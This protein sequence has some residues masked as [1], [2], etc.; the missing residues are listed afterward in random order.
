M[1]PV[2][3]GSSLP[4]S[5][6]SSNCVIWQGPDIPCISLCNGDTVSDVV[7]KL[8]TEVCTLIDTVCQ[9][10]PDLTGLDLMCILPAC[11][12]TPVGIKQVLQAIIDYICNYMPTLTL[13]ILNLPDCL[14]YNDSLG[15]RV[16]QLPLDEYV[17]LLANEFCTVKGTVGRHET[18]INQ[19]LLDVEYILNNC[20][21][22]GLVPPQASIISQCLIPGSGVIDVNTLV[23]AI[24]SAFCNLQNAVG[25]TILINAAINQQCLFSS[26]ATLS[27]SGTYG[28]ISGWQSSS[29]TLAQSTQN[30]WV[31]V[32][33]M[34]T[35]LKNIQENCCN[36]G[37]DSVNFGFTYGVLADSYGVINAINL[38]FTSTTFPAS[39][40]DCGGSTLITV[41]DSNGSS[42]TA[43][44]NVSGL[45]TDPSGLNINVSTLNTLQSLTVKINFCVTDGVNT[46]SEIKNQII[47]LQIPCPIDV[48]ISPSLS[49]VSIQ[50]TNPFGPGIVYVVK[51]I[52]STTS[53]VAGSITTV[54][55]STTVTNSFTGLANGTA[56]QVSIEVTS[57]SITRICPSGSF[58]TLG[59][60]C[61]NIVTTTLSGEPTV[62]SSLYLGYSTLG[63]T[64]NWYSYDSAANSIS[65]QS[66]IVTC[67][68]PVLSS[69]SI[70]LAGDVTV[71]TA[72]GSG[73]NQNTITLEY[74]IDNI[75]WLGTSVGADGI[76]TLPTGVTSGLVYVRANDNCDVPDGDSIYAEL[77]YS[78][79]TGIW[80][81][82]AAP[83]ECVN[84]GII[85]DMCPVGTD[86]QSDVLTCG[87]ITNTIPGGGSPSTW[88][89]AGIMI[90]GGITHYI[91]AGWA[92]GLGI[93]KVV[94]CCECPA[95]ILPGDL[96]VY[97]GQ[98]ST[99]TFTLPYLLGSGAP[100]FT[101]ITSPQY[102][103][104]GQTTP[105][106]NE[107]NYVHNGLS[108]FGDTFQVTLAP[109]VGGQCQTTTYTVQIQIIPCETGLTAIDQPIFAFI[110]TNSNSVV[111]GTN[112][113]AGLGLLY[114]SLNSTY[115]YTGDIYIVPVT[116]S[117]WLGYAKAIVDDGVSA[118]LDGD[119]SWVALQNLPTSWSAGPAIDKTRAFV[120]AF[121]N[122]SY[123]EYHDNSLA[124]GWGSG[125]TLQ[126]TTAYG[127][128]YDEFKDIINGTS[129]SAW[130]AALGIAT[131]QFP[132]GFTGVYYPITVN[133]TGETAA[134]ILQGLGCYVAQMIQPD[135]YG[136]KTAV[137]VSGYLMAGLIPSST[138]PYQAAVTAG[139]NTILGLYKSKWIMFLN[140]L[141]TWDFSTGDT[142]TKF[143]SD[144]TLA[145]LGCDGTFPV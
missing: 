18:E 25:D 66:E 50:F 35:A 58:T 88:F 118:L 54:S 112:I 94:A 87:G 106:G 78:W 84:S 107:F 1:I 76:R 140:Q 130:A 144:V 22:Q 138:N 75:T 135:E 44:A 91:Y 83:G 60:S 21:N 10:E 79:T 114:T 143:L 43:N 36:N 27:T 42:I 49:S 57:G 12:C 126:P 111:Q 61:E 129:I 77:V 139:G 40:S 86:I 4:C 53:L 115:G 121:S 74:S 69:P 68:P 102:G 119:P 8:A 71:T 110:D 47:P 132:N 108:S 100:Y 16:T 32:C 59:V 37:C 85:T 133:S 63:G 116:D 23:L 30:L 48:A 99:S 104:I 6:I 120:L 41:T 34:Y 62:G 2:N 98:S 124:A 7:A 95:F 82:L 142:S 65:I 14:Q 33:D 67:Y 45:K 137:D 92:D 15:N 101:I 55:P 52:D 11:E 128:N 51:I 141:G 109:L 105:G 136:I 19:L 96:T 117:Q 38:N 113:V 24:E 97:C 3:S 70:N 103:S 127:T 80:T 81:V 39:Y 5:P 123:S 131:P 145:T 31:I 72:Y 56:Y 29:N 46:C 13:P 64:T 125:M 73:V 93:T 89:Y 134:A 90:I 122:E 26:D 28:S 17:I 9:C 20:C